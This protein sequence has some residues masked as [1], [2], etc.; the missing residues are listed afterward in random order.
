M[1]FG[2]I[3]LS[4]ALAAKAVNAD[5]KPC[6]AT[7]VTTTEGKE[8]TFIVSRDEFASEL[9]YFQFSGID[10]DCGSTNPTLGIEKGATYF[11]IQSD[12][13]NYYH[14]L[15]FA[16]GADGALDD[17]D[18]LEP[19]IRGEGSTSTCTENNSCPAP[20][21][22]QGADYLGKYSNNAVIAPLTGDDVDPSDDFGLDGYEPQFFN[23]LGDWI[24]SETYSVSLY[25]PTD[26]D[27]EGD[28]F[29]FCHIHQFMTGR[30]K[31]IDANGNP[32]TEA[33]HPIIPYDYQ[34]P[35]EYDQ[36]CGT[37]GLDEFQLP[38]KQCPDKFVCNRPEGA[39]GKFAE[40][41]DS[42]NC[43]MLAGM[44]TNVNVDSALAL[45]NHQMIPHH[46]NAVNMC[47]ALLISGEADCDDLSDEDDNA[48]VINALCQEI[49]NVQNAQ[50]QTMRGVLSGIDG[51]SQTDDCI[52]KIKTNNK[53][54]KSDKDSGKTSKSEKST[55]SGSASVSRSSS[56][57]DTPPV[58]VSSSS[59]SDDTP[60]V[61]VSSSSEDT[62]PVVVSSSSSSE[63]VPAPA[64][65]QAPV[66]GDD[67]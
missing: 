27:F 54:E 56:S 64:P 60:P 36:S 67:D 9:G 15:G 7:C 20:M 53:K 49:I 31:F 17:Q 43:A 13:S 28:F 48:C 66:R 59:S 35:S 6:R 14:P 29:Y 10:G 38:N 34:V 1:K 21:Y 24:G 26:N 40:C 18:E 65:V 58:E 23:P 30:I 57:D 22:S 61:E 5:D 39:V 41:V 44:T 16:Y 3:V 2:S 11:F 4:I 25:Y 19:G 46:Q 47:K 8:C 37:F 12:V 33:N 42:M 32:I 50:I 51:A 63:D 52:V 62:P 55:K 45:F